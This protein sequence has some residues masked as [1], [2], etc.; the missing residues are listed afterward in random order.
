MHRGRSRTALRGA[1]AAAAA[2]V[3][4]LATATA[5]AD[6]PADVTVIAGV[7]L[8]GFYGD[9]VPGPISGVRLPGGLAAAP[10]GGLYFTEQ[11]GGRVRKIAADGTVTGV[12]GTLNATGGFAGD[13]GPAASAQLQFPDGVAADSHGNVFVADTGNQRIRKIG[14]DGIITTVAGTGFAGYGGDG[15]PATAAYLDRPTALAIDRFDNLYIADA[16]N[17]RVRKIDAGGTIT[18]FAGNGGATFTPTG[19]GGQADAA[20][21]SGPAA[22]AVTHDYL[23]FAE[24]ADIRKVGLADHVLSTVGGTGEATYLGNRGDGGPAATA[25]LN[26]PYGVGADSHGNVFIADAGNRAI[27]EITP[28]GIIHA[29]IAM[30]PGQLAVDNQDGVYFVDAGHSLILKLGRVKISAKQALPL[31]SNHTCTSH[32]AF[33]IRVRRYRG[34]SYVTATVAINGRPIPVYVYTD[35]RRKV[36][37]VGAVYLNARRFRAFIDLRGRAKGTYKVKVTATTTDG[38]TLAATRT[39]HTCARNGRLTGSIPR[40]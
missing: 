7:T 4:L 40:L 35:R 18:T 27:R 36:T 29:V 8:G 9:D 32:R 21:L 16:G 17:N 24:H 1:A 23:Y 10:D 31:P 6:V 30:D 34:V 25:T 14:P 2:A 3:L 13:G 39:Y 20:P 37:K 19:D 26:Q 15:G 28:D 22:L 33:P 11:A 5:G 12:A 38:R